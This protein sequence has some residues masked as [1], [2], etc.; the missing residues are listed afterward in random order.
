MIFDHYPSICSQYPKF[1]AS[2]AVVEHTL[3]WIQ[4]A[5][6]NPYYYEESFL[7]ALAAVVGNPMKVETIKNKTCEYMYLVM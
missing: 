4:F 6:L 2:K 3:V 5:S 1:K 7:F